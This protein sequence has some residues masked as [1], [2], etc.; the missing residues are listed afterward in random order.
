MAPALNSKERNKAFWKF[1]LFFSISV[2]VICMAVFVNFI[3]P[4]K[5]NKILKEKAGKFQAHASSEEKFSANLLEV[6]KLL[7]SLNS[8]GVNEVYI[9]Q[10]INSKINE[11]TKANHDDKEAAGKADQIILDVLLKYSLTKSKL[12]KLSNASQE[13]ESYKRDLQACRLELEGARNT[14]TLLRNSGGF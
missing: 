10:L 3:V 12:S 2:V 6:D 7:D 14:I 13:L 5:E 11:M 9:T 4:S 1:V 8:P